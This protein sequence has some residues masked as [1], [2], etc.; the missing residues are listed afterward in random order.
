MAE[1][2]TV[3]FTPVAMLALMVG[4]GGAASEEV[5]VY[6]SVD[7]VF[8]RPVAERFEQA[9]GIVVRLV[10]DTEET[11]S[12]GLVNRL[13]AERRRPRADVF[14][15]G[16]PVRA[17]LLKGH[18]ISASYRS[19]NAEGLPARYT[20]PEGHW[21]G[22][23][24]RARVL[25]YNRALVPD[26]EEPSSIMD[27]LEPRFQGQ[28]CIANPLFGTTSMHA[29]ALFEVLGA[30]RAHRF[31][32]QFIEN[33]GR[34]V[35]SNGEVRRRVAAGDFAVGL[36]DTDDANV[37]LQEGKPV[38]V[39]YPDQ[40]TIGTLII[41]N[42]VVLIADGPNPAAARRFIDYLL[43][44]ETEKALAE[45]DAAQMPLRSGIE[46][47]DHVRPLESISSMQVDY[48]KLAERL[49]Q[50]SR[51]FLKDWVDANS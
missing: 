3:R 49:E 2:N 30:E 7:D 31:F 5:V 19:P 10:P 13:I 4:C 39:V 11:K 41:P 36:T 42:A 44:P 27:L 24:A 20:D 29:A 17:A 34:I 51:A 14:W 26:G 38:G 25:I 16:D 18:G 32:E 15:S 47:P 40:N 45:S 37:A 12:T 8:A 22:F 6:T 23:S 50:L 9:T 48:V 35:S 46:V 43:Q 33:G 1:R 21:T 28:S